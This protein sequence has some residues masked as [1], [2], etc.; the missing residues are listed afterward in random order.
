MPPRS[1]SGII[2]RSRDSDAELILST[3]IEIPR[4]LE[5]DVRHN[6]NVAHLVST[7]GVVAYSDLHMNDVHR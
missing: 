5:K 4:I 3:V 7:F 2:A 6:S 1:V